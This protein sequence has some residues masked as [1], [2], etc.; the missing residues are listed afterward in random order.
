MEIFISMLVFAVS[1]L[2][3]GKMI[4]KTESKKQL[5]IEKKLIN[6]IISYYDSHIFGD[7]SIIFGKL[8]IL[9]CIVGIFFYDKMGLLSIALVCAILLYYLVNIVVGFYKFYNNKEYKMKSNTKTL[10][11][12]I[13]I[14]L[15][16]MLVYGIYM[17]SIMNNPS[18]YFRQV[19]EQQVDNTKVLT[20]ELIDLPSNTSYELTFD[21][22]NSDIGQLSNNQKYKE[23]IGKVDIYYRQD[24]GNPK[25]IFKID[26][27]DN[28]SIEVI[29]VDSNFQNIN[30]TYEV[31]FTRVEKELSDN[32]G[33]ELEIPYTSKD[34]IRKSDNSI[35]IY[36]SENNKEST[37]IRMNIYQK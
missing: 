7:T 27:N 30:K 14:E 20:Y 34:T 29:G 35:G 16:F 33:I 5:E 4:L 28:C 9:P 37:S 6:S 1:S 19:D 3:I 31:Q 23:N 25:V 32:I 18:A 2:F 36:G 17:F 22:V 8:M 12:I 13:V 24:V 21:V 26:K 10:R 15:I 11:Y